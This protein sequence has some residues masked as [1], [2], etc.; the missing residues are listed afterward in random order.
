MRGRYKRYTKQNLL[1][2]NMKG[3]GHLED[4]C[5]DGRIMLKC[6]LNKH[7]LKLRIGFI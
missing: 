3:K 4:R 1:F 5:V 6:I 7:A 2:V